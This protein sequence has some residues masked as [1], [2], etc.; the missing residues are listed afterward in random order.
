MNEKNTEEL[1]EILKHTHI[2]EFGKFRDENLYGF[3]EDQEAFSIYI[4][5]LLAKRGITQQKVFLNADIPERYGYKLLSGEKRTKQRDV[6][7]RIC[8]AAEL[9]LDETQKALRKYGMPELYAKKE[10][11]AVLMIV[12]NER[13]GSIIDV[14]SILKENDLLPLRTSGIQE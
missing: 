10:R 13:P 5:E 8:Y 1:S 11:D 12:F 2:S 14:N 7:L 9:S 6:I 4:K 3:S